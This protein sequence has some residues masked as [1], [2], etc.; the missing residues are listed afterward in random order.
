MNVTSARNLAGFRAISRCARVG[1]KPAN[2]THVVSAA[3]SAG[4]LIPLPRRSFGD[5]R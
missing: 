5:A 1:K 3:Q 2:G 4:D